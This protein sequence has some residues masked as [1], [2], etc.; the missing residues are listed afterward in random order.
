MVTSVDLQDSVCA[1]Q[2]SDLESEVDFLQGSSTVSEVVS[3]P[4]TVSVIGE[5][6]CQCDRQEELREGLRVSSEYL[7]GEEDQGEHI[8]YLLFVSL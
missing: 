5:S 7:C 3:L 1:N 2:M 8:L 4:R 6:F